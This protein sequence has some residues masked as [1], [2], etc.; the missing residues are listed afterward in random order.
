MK[1]YATEYINSMTIRTSAGA[2]ISARN[3]SIDHFTISFPFLIFS[4]SQ[5]ESV[6]RSA[7]YTIAQIASSE[8]SLA[9]LVTQLSTVYLKP[10]SSLA[11]Q[12]FTRSVPQRHPSSDPE[13]FPLTNAQLAKTG[14]S[15]RDIISIIA[16]NIIKNIFIFCD[17]ILSHETSR[18]AAQAN[19][20]IK[21][22]T[23]A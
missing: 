3:Q 6:I 15:I 11:S 23:A 12:G 1:N 9:I 5:T 20:T 7:P 19:S 13:T 22:P 18:T 17:Y 4:S 14:C 16:R 21:I 2:D 10:Q 8:R